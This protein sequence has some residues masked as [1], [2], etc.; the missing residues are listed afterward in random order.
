VEASGGV[1]L[2]E[3][4]VRCLVW[5]GEEDDP[6]HVRRETLDNGRSRGARRGPK[7]EHRTHALQRGVER[8]GLGE[9][10]RHDLDGRRQRGRRRFARERAHRHARAQEL[11]DHRA[12][13]PTG[14]PRY[15]DGLHVDPFVVRIHTT[16]APSRPGIVRA[17]QTS[18][19]S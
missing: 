13:D 16:L 2:L 6:P 15:Q 5:R 9:V 1:R 4:R 10:T 12:P 11:G 17:W 7:E 18:T 8:V 3:E 14:G 19:S